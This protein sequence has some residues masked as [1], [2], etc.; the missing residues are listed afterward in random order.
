MNVTQHPVTTHH[1]AMPMPAEPPQLAR[2][3]GYAGLVPLV[4]SM[5]LIWL[6]RPE[7]REWVAQ[8]LASF[9]AVIVAFLGGV[10]WGL[11]MPIPS[12]GPRSFGWSAVPPLVAA[13]GMVMPFEAG[14]VVLGVMMLVCYGVDRKF[15]VAHGLAAWLTLRFR[16]SLAAA[17]CCFLGAA[18]CGTGL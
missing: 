11:S 16:L 13:I 2:R 5:L 14:L 6:V 8:C 17:L 9:A 12:K 7:L 4:V 18:G 15:Y 10:H 3:W 1:V